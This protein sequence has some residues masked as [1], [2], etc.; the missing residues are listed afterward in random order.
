L[1]QIGT[2]KELLY[3]SGGPAPLVLAVQSPNRRLR[4]AALQAIVRLQPSK[5]FA[6]S[7]YVLPALGFFAGSSGSRHALVAAPSLVEAR[8]LAGMLVAAGYETDTFTNGRE[9][10]L[11]A[12]QSPD[13]ELALIDVA[14]DHPTIEILL[15]Q[16]RHDAR[17]ASL[18]VGLIARSGHFDEVERLEGLNPLTKG[19]SRPHDNKAFRWQLD[20]LATLA[21][22]E[23][24]GFEARQRQAAEAFDLLAELG[25]SSRK[26]YDLRSVQPQVIA[27]VYNPKLAAKAVGVLADINSA[28]S[29]QTLVEVASRFTLPLALRQAAAKAFRQN[30]QRHGILLTTEQIRRQ[31]QRY[32]DSEKLDAATQHVLALVLDCLEV[33]VPKK[34]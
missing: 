29:Q 20:Q 10:V 30:T 14:I 26:L 32:N 31:Y 17:T 23:F 6:G 12:A 8:E 28:E 22:Q 1:G 27:A 25:R 2:A 4:M 21:P 16:L 3:Q 18:R 7:S 24:V 34:K 5:P 11:A 9:L 13:Y 33:G 15:Q 19:F